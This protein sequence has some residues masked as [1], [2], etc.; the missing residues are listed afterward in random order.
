MLKPI[1]NLKEKIENII[2]LDTWI[3]KINRINKI[4]KKIKET[5]K[6]DYLN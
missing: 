6:K 5:I 1:E 4:I 2:E 3:K